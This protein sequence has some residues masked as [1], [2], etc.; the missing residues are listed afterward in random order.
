MHMYYTFENRVETMM[1]TSRECR[2]PKAKA[3]L[4]VRMVLG[5]IAKLIVS[6]DT[7]HEIFSEI[8]SL[9]QN[10]PRKLVGWT[11]EVSS[12]PFNEKTLQMVSETF[13]LQHLK[14]LYFSRF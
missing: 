3:I 9:Q 10:P 11:Y 4:E 13:N 5:E 14:H 8:A 12:T 7:S 2:K 6:G 1:K